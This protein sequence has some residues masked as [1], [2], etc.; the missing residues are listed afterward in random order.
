[1]F[2]SNAPDLTAEHISPDY[3]QVYLRA[4]GGACSSRP[5]A[6]QPGAVGGAGADSTAPVIS[7]LRMTRTRFAVRKRASAFVFRLSEDSRASVSIARCVKLRKRTCRRYRVVATL[8]RAHAKQ[9]PNRIAF[10]GRIGKRKLKPGRYRATVGAVDA[11]GNRAVPRRVR[12]RI[13]RARAHR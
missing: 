2:S 12:F 4:V 3:S 9:G 1:V 7:G 6:G 11:A 8:T 10:S 5:D 13:V